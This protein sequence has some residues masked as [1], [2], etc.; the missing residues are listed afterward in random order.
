MQSGVL[1]GAKF[2][3]NLQIS[4]TI[5]HYLKKKFNL[6]F[7]KYEEVRTYTFKI[8][9]VQNPKFYGN[10]SNIIGFGLTPNRQYFEKTEYSRYSFN[11]LVSWILAMLGFFELL[12][13]L[14][15]FL[16]EGFVAYFSKKS[17]NLNSVS[18]P[19]S[20]PNHRDYALL[21]SEDN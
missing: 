3:L 12:A 15:I 17:K 14:I 19:M 5:R 10:S 9:G 6:D 4:V 21:N 1:V 20:H 18:E 13:R 2:F 11:E 8:N 7:L 16:G